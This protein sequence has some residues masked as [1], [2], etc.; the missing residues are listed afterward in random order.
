[1]SSFI[2]ETDTAK[3]KT[4]VFGDK[5]DTFS[6][7]NIIY[8]RSVQFN[9]ELFVYK[10]SIALGSWNTLQTIDQ[11]CKVFYDA[12]QLFINELR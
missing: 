4:C 12:R 2:R 1:M 10:L 3:T 11:Q 6:S 7:G 9:G 5:P 8:T